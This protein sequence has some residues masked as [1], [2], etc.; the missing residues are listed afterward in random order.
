MIDLY[1]SITLR[2]SIIKEDTKER[3][4]RIPGKSPSPKLTSEKLDIKYAVSSRPGQ[5]S[6]RMRK[7]N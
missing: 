3:F 4:E 2:R 6:N 1:S 5:Y 7:I